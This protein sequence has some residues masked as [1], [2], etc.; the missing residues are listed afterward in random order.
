M[1]K[2]KLTSMLTELNDY[3]PRPETTGPA[4]RHMLAV[5]SESYEFITELSEQ[6]KTSRGKVV[7]A[8]VKF[9]RDSE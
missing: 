1:P 2:E 4:K 8:L 3:I 6:L 5:D 7:T 9:F